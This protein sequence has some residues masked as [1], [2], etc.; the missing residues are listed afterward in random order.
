MEIL[1]KAAQLILS[2][3]ILVVLHELGHF[4]S[5]KWFK[6]RVEKFYLFFDPWFSL[7]KIKKGDT[8]Y[9]IG[10]IPL[11]GYVKISGMIDE[12]MD[13]EQMK[14]PAQ[15]WEF[16]A[17]PAWQRLIVMVGGVTMNLLLAMC[18]YAMLLFVF[19]EKYLPTANMK[20]GV[21]CIDSL[22]NQMGFQNGDKILSVDNKK[23]EKFQDIVP[24]MM[25]ATSMQIERKGEKINLPIP[26]NF[27]EQIIDGKG[28]HTPFLYPRIPFY[29]G[30][31]SDASPAEK[32]GLKKKDQVIGINDSTLKYF[33]EFKAMVS[34]FKNQTVKLKVKRGNEIMNVSVP[35]D[36]AGKIGVATA[37]MDL[38]SLRESG[39]YDF[40]VTKYGFFESFPAGIRK[41]GD[42]L[43][44]YI[45]QFKLIFNF[46]TGAYKGVGSFISIGNLFPA[47]WEWEPFWE[48][49]AILSIV[50]AFMNILPIPALDGGHVMFLL[51][52][53][54]TGKKPSDK[55]L[56][57][58]QYVGMFLLI[59]LMVYAIGN[60][61]FRLF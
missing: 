33:D 17:K 47:H 44:D 28:K 42:K 55:F 31:F 14:Q 25:Y 43:V 34:P 26:K 2:L 18:I 30:G 56:E 36:T 49:T 12:S 21:W 13:K 7:F 60:D 10:W 46:K 50:L 40:S 32:A 58:A 1:I 38:K 8:E 11:G 19:G 59:S 23:V 39:V 15:P 5:A 41:A 9:G 20:D 24:E 29:I 22:A 35:V 52:E 6:M 61:I 54:I 37:M 4:A 3:S 53:V 27:I 45:H 57:Y 51:Y 16:R 48:L